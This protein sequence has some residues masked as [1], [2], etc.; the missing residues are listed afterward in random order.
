MRRNISVIKFSI[1]FLC[2]VTI[3]TNGCSIT[4]KDHK[5]Q[6]TKTTNSLITF[7]PLIT[8]TNT[9]TPTVLA[10]A[11]PTH[12]TATK[13]PALT[14]TS[15]ATTTPRVPIETRMQ[16]DC[17]EITST[18][19]DE[20]DDGRRVV[21][22]DY[23]SGPR[24]VYLLNPITNEKKEFATVENQYPD[25]I[26]IS[27][28]GH[29]L[30]YT[31]FDSNDQ[32]TI[33]SKSLVVVNP[34][35]QEIALVSGKDWMEVSRWL[36]NERLLVKHNPTNPITPQITGLTM[37]NPFTG[38]QKELSTDFPD[39]WALG[40]MYE[41]WK[42]TETV[43]DP[44]LTR[45]IYPMM[46]ND[47]T[48]IVLENYTN[49]KIITR[50]S[51]AAPTM[52]PIWS[53]DGSKFIIANT[54]GDERSNQYPLFELFNVTRDGEITQL[55][56]FMSYYTRTYITNYRWSP[57]GRYIVFSLEGWRDDAE[58][59]D[60]SWAVL[61]TQTKEITNYC[62]APYKSL[63]TGPFWSPDSREF[64]VEVADRNSADKSQLILV[65][66]MNNSA[67]QVAENVIPYGWM[68]SP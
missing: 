42:L 66:I 53:I 64:I 56:N 9:I 62:L 22:R 2:I 51:P 37:V 47:G 15:T 6:P 29:W 49:H 14:Q 45:V 68:T 16:F 40:V 36:D 67:V 13:T 31:I 21:F 4:N 25:D 39:L 27:P 24:P 12:T 44:N 57:D 32:D 63:F 34:T 17:L 10:A 19:I 60:S 7:T 55:T 5:T 46:T 20:I 48:D 59:A 52:I 50:L 54:L 18:R 23:G 38:E 61:D 30:A 26:S 1:L 58:N 33:P 8:T 43:F 65:N 11:I 35:G 3:L 28:N 41:W